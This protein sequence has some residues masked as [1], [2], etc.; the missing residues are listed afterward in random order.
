MADDR[1][2]QSQSPRNGLTLATVVIAPELSPP[3][4][5]SQQQLTLLS[6][7]L[8]LLPQCGQLGPTLEATGQPLIGSSNGLALPGSERFPGMQDFQC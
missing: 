3:T 1:D 7:P 4:P 5:P 2:F 8:L 6:S